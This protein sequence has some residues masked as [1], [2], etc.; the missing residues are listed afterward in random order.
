MKFYGDYQVYS[1]SGIDL[2][3]LRANLTRSLEERLGR[4]AGALRFV[5]AA[6]SAGQVKGQRSSGAAMADLDVEA[7]L[8][9]LISS[10]VDFVLIGGLAMV[11]QGSAHVTKD[12]DLCYGRS[13]ENL[14]RVVSAFTPL[15][16]YLRGAPAGLPFR[17]DVPT[18]QAGL[19]FTLVTDLGDVDLLG[20]VKGIGRYEHVLARSEEKQLFGLPVRVLSLDGLIDAKKAAGRVKDRNHLLELEEIRKLREANPGGN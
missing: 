19:N 15:R 14:S 13:P 18:L 17:L 7:V 20:E 12:I 10:Q 3:L 16:P 11:V 1:D 4:N 2:T 9:Q 6:R 8:R 5:A